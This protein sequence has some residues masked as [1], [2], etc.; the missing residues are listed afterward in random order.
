MPSPCW[1]GSS[2]F[3]VPSSYQG[4]HIL[5]NHLQWGSQVSSKQ[6][7][8]SNFS[9]PNWD[10]GPIEYDPC[11]LPQ[12]LGH[13]GGDGRGSLTIA[14]NSGPCQ[15]VAL[16]RALGLCKTQP[17][18]CL[19]TPYLATQPKGLEGPGQRCWS[20]YFKYRESDSKNLQRLIACLPHVSWKLALL[21]PFE[22]FRRI[23]KCVCVCVISGF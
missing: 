11:R 9:L 14:L 6:L 12:A 15:W 16:A 21:T 19:H 10:L 18:A 1:G 8:L 23:F 7:A 3:S 22:D 20:I 17:L 2:E 4:P 5:Y 13:W